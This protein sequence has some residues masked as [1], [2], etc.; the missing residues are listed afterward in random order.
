LYKFKPGK[1][2]T[3]RRERPHKVPAVT[4]L[5]K[6]N[7]TKQNKTKQNK[8]NKTLSQWDVN[9]IYQP[10]SR[11]GSM[12]RRR[13]PGGTQVFFLCTSVLVLLVLLVVFNFFI[14]FGFYF[15]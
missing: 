8:Q 3:Q 11:V 6:E 14:S 7:K 2:P 9:G 10:H 15:L 1:I 4:K 5:K 12:P 13:W